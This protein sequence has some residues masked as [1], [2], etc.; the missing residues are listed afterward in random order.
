MLVVE[1]EHYTAYGNANANASYDIYASVAKMNCKA[2]S[3][4][5]LLA[6]RNEKVI[7]R[8]LLLIVPRGE[9]T[10]RLENSQSKMLNLIMIFIKYRI[11]HLERIISKLYIIAS[12]NCLVLASPYT[13]SRSTLQPKPKAQNLKLLKAGN[14]DRGKDHRASLEIALVSSMHQI[15]CDNMNTKSVPSADQ[16]Y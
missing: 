12:I 5:P 11:C 9:E 2:L 6:F 13:F 3:N 16:F 8:A 10:G 15:C 7:D 14:S 1:K 4:K